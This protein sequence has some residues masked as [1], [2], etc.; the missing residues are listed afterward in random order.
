MLI[1]LGPILV[2]LH[3]VVDGLHG[4]IKK[5]IRLTYNK[6]IDFLVKYKQINFTML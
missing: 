1:G 3:Y 2:G 6:Q 4:L 5:E